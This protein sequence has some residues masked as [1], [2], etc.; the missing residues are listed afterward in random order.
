[1]SKPARAVT[2][3]LRRVEYSLL[4]PFVFALTWLELAP[5]ALKE[6]LAR[7]TLCVALMVA[8]MAVTDIIRVAFA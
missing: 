1:M 4:L 7:G 8:S 5:A 3:A 6:N 2:L